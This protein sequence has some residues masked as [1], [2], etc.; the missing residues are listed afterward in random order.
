MFVDT[1]SAQ[2]APTVTQ[3]ATAPEPPKKFV[4]LLTDGEEIHGNEIFTEAEA[5]EAQDLADTH[6]GGEFTWFKASE[7]P[8]NSA[9]AASWGEAKA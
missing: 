4:Y 3:K 9:T 8:V 7:L 5:A 6:G 2:V 1:F